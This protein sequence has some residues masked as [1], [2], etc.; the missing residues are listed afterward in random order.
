MFQS[1]AR[2]SLIRLAMSA[3]Q[4]CQAVSDRWM[5]N[6]WPLE[7]SWLLIVEV[8]SNWE[9]IKENARGVEEKTRQDV[10][11]GL[12]RLEEDG[13]CWIS[14]AFSKS[15]FS[16]YIWNFAKTYFP[17]IVPRE[18]KNVFWGKT[19]SNVFIVAKHIPF[20][21]FQSNLTVHSGESAN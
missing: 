9:K 6:L 21:R 1:K 4:L 15:L 2:V 16:I 14:R 17:K 13:W 8:K 11:H 7:I 19:L 3:L 12:S 18:S 20:R 10:H 5:Y